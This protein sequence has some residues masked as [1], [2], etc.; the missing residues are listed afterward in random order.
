MPDETL[1]TKRRNRRGKTGARKSLLPFEG[2]KKKEG[3]SVES[4]GAGCVR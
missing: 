3:W 2:Q 1:A 4:K